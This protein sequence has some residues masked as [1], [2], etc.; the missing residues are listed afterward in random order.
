M[1]R[2]DALGLVVTDMAATVAFYSRLGL[3]FPAGSDGEAHVT[4]RFP[5]KRVRRVSNGLRADSVENFLVAL[6]LV[7]NR[8]QAGDLNATYH[9]TFHG[10]EALEA[11]VVIADGAVQVATG[12]QGRADVHIRADSRTWIKF[13]AKE[14]NIVWESIRGRVKV[15]GPLALLKRFAACFPA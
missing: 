8:Q 9:F 14:K 2:F 1:A 5:H 15:K 10:D 12:S 7:F 4:K 13:L 11:T 3:G 6:P